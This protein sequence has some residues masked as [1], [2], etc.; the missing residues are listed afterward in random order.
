MYMSILGYFFSEWQWW[1][2]LIFFRLTCKFLDHESEH[3]GSVCWPNNKIID[4][5]RIEV[6]D[7][8]GCELI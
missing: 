1:V 8:M 4:V 7:G 5:A 3:G 6:I 2:I